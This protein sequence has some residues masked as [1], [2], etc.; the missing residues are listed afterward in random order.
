MINKLLQYCLTIWAV[1]TLNFFLPRMIP[2]NPLA[3]LDTVEGLPVALSQEQRDQIT[4][5]YG[6]DQP[7]PTQYARY[8]RGLAHGDLGWSISYNAPVS[9]VLIGRLKWTALVVG[10]STVLY[11]LLGIAL[12]GLSAWHHH[13]IIDKVI[14]LGGSAL[15]ALPSFFVGMLL[16]MLFAVRLRWLPLSGARSA[17]SLGATG[18]A[19]LGDIARHM[20]LP[21][22]ALVLTSVGQVSYLT[23]NAL[24]QV[25]GQGYITAARARGLRERSLLVRHALPNALLPVVAFV[26]LRLGFIAMGAVM[27]ETTFAFPGIGLA[28][29]EAS[30]SRDYAMLQ[31]AFAV[32]TVSIIVANI[33]GD[34]L[35]H[36]IDPRLR[37][38]VQ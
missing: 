34:L 33:I 2:G 16:V 14:L 9:D 35:Q 37:R 25:L 21:V 20:I 8:I 26:A 5:Y 18:G 13:R 6:L 15:G 4:A 27:I 1:L 31:G 7:L 3:Q 38:P 10:A 28:I 22:M 24:V 11:V 12:G 30:T 32:V 29:V 36:V 23:R 17:T 19:Y